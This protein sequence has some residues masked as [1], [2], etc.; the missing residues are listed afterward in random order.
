MSKLVWDK[1]MEARLVRAWNAGVPASLLGERF[2]TSGAAIIVK[3]GALRAN[4]VELR[5]DPSALESSRRRQAQRLRLYDAHY[6]G[7]AT[8][9]RAMAQGSI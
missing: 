1:G 6:R 3:I 2:G 4:G 9:G 5:Y 7:E 8:R